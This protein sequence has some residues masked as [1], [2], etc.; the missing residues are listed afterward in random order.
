MW[1][2]D[3]YEDAYWERRERQRAEEAEYEKA[4]YDHMMQVEYDRYMLNRELLER[5]IVGVL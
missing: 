5:F 3:P 4:M 2:P 1:D